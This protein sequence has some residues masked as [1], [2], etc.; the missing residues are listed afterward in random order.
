MP[1]FLA[2]KC[3]FFLESKGFFPVLTSVNLSVYPLKI[4]GKLS[5]PPAVEKKKSSW[6][7]LMA[8]CIWESNESCFTTEAT[9]FLML[10]DRAHPL[11]HGTPPGFNLL[12]QE[13]V[14][15]VVNLDHLN[16]GNQL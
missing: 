14:C 12:T 10:Y 15:G 7:S 9:L 13:T 8:P 1:V 3:L 11:F 2:S 4:I 16:S 5:G 6:V